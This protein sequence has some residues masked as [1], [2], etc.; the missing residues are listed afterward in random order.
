MKDLLFQ[1]NYT[2]TILQRQRYQITVLTKELNQLQLIGRYNSGIRV[3]RHMA[4]RFKAMLY[5]HEPN[6]DKHFLPNLKYYIN[7]HFFVKESTGLLSNQDF[8]RFS[9]EINLFFQR[10]MKEH[11]LFIET[12]LTPVETALIAEA[13]ILKEGFEQLLAETVHYADRAISISAINSN[14]FVTPYTLKA[15]ELTSKFTGASINTEITKAE[16][17]LTG[18]QSFPDGYFRE[19]SERIVGDLNQRSMNLLEK[20]ISFKKKLLALSAECKIFIV[21]YDEIIDHITQEAEY[22]LELLKALRNKDLPGRTVCEELNF[23]NY[24]MAGHASFIDGL[25]DPTET[26]L[27][28]T[29]RTFIDGFDRLVKGCTRST[30]NQIKRESLQLTEKIRNF[31]RSATE[32]ILRCG[33]KSIIIPLL[34]DHVLREANYYLRLLRMMN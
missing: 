5:L 26:N 33:I 2:T 13:A 12:S 9:L 32:G 30:E 24:T 34:A 17:E 31:K 4:A 27:K 23:W 14:E 3:I 11:L 7:V 29:A 18:L 8:I 1:I 10:I 16:Y 15:E 6:T 22:Y 25:L 19:S 28:E 21:L 20:V